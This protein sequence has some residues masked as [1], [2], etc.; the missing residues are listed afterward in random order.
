MSLLPAAGDQFFEDPGGFG[1]HAG[2]VVL[3]GADGECRVAVPES[4]AHDLDDRFLSGNRYA[5][6]GAWGGWVE[7]VPVAESEAHGHTARCIPVSFRCRGRQ[8]VSRELQQRRSGIAEA[9]LTLIQDTLIWQP[10][11]RV[12]VLLRLLGLE[13]ELNP[14]LEKG[15]GQCALRRLNL[16]P[17]RR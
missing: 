6:R 5:D 10:G 12:T 7:R 4:S 9:V 17:F 3:V 16:A 1:L 15:R 8:I 14:E 11:D 13:R 2:Q